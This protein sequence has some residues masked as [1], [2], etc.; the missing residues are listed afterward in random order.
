[1]INRSFCLTLLAALIMST[2]VMAQ[3]LEKK[4]P[5]MPAPLETMSKEGAQVRYMGHRGGLD[6]WIAIQNGQEQYFYATEDREFVLLGLLFDKTGKMITLEQVGE[7]QKQGGAVLDIL[8]ADTSTKGASVTDTL[9]VQGDIAKSLKSPSEQM[10]SDIEAGNW[11]VL[12]Q[13]GAP[14]LYSFMD[15]QCPF[16]HEF[17][18]SLRPEIE[19]GRIQVRLLPVGFHGEQALAQAALLLAA[20]NAQ[21]R[22]F[23]HV[24]GDKEALPV[25]PGI[26]EQG[27]ER[28]MAIMQSWKLDVTPISMYRAQD[29]K[30]KIVQ[31]RAKDL[32]ALLSDLK[33]TQ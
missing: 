13:E 17:M 10:F 2:P 25:T 12:G 28:N 27:I 30:V 16:C 14:I 20:P 31:G 19:G 1:M 23:R 6:G 5:P 21:D 15:P 4:D 26:N 9:P 29:G 3:T 33:V 7:L 24:N 18:K 32:K 11:I 8:K 22:W